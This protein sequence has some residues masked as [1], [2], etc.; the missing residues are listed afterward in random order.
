MLAE[1]RQIA[2]NTTLYV[3]TAC[4]C[5]AQD[6]VCLAAIKR[7]LEK[8]CPELDFQYKFNCEI[9]DNKRSWILALHKMLD[10]QDNRRQTPAHG[11]ADDD[12]T[13]PGPCLFDD[14]Q[15]M[16]ACYAH[17]TTPPKAKKPMPSTCPVKE[18]DILICSTSCKDYSKMHAKRVS[19]SIINTGETPGGSAQTLHGLNLLIE[20]LRPI[21]IFYENVG[22]M[23]KKL[24]PQDRSDLEK[25]VG[26][27]DSY[28]YESQV[29]YIDTR[30]FGVPQA[31]L[32]MYIV[33]FRKSHDNVKFDVH[34]LQD[35]MTS[36]KLLLQIC[37]RK[38]ACASSYLLDDINEHVLKE[39][40]HLQSNRAARSAEGYK[41]HDAMKKATDAGI[42]WRACTNPPD[43]LR[44]SHWYQTLTAQQKH[45]LCFCLRKAPGNHLLRN[46]GDSF[47]RCRVSAEKKTKDDVHIAGTVLPGNQ[48]MIFD[49]QPGNQR[50]PHLT[51][52]REHLRLQGFPIDV[53]D[54]SLIHI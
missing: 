47:G 4:T 20:R 10:E 7:A 15:K 5:S 43:F 45:A 31:R 29:N 2:P 44:K 51:I 42:A 46:V 1:D 33:A 53:L 39:F 24:T 36:F 23:D 34:N 40:A 12:V 21:M 18:I 13:D 30:Q 17:A 8:I 50:M 48:C 6:A 26:T 49:D 54:L 52:G 37:E 3:G 14:I 32:R 22:D 35:A 9:K 19:G 28:G 25:L 27:W 38:A 41:M 11:L 16:T